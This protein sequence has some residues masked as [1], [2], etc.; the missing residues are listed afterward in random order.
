[1]LDEN[2]IQEN[3]LKLREMVNTEFSGERADNLNRLYDYFEE[4]MILAP[5]SGKEHFHNAFPGGYVDH[6]LRVIDLS[7]KEMELW[8]SAGAIINFTRE[9]LVFS[10]MHHDL[11]KV[12]D[13][14]N[15][16]Y[17]PN[18]SQWHTE[19]QG[20]I[21]AFNPE[22]EHTPGHLQTQYLLQ[23]FNVYCSKRE[24]I[25]I[26]C[27]DGMYSTDAESILKQYEASRQLRSNLPLILH[28]AD[29][30]A[31]RVEYDT[32]YAS[33]STIIEQKEEVKKPVTFKKQNL[34]KL[35]SIAE[36]ATTEA[37]R[38]LFDDLF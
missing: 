25:A 16:Y 21:Y 30:L 23:Y 31:S 17:I 18:D 38:K 6:V 14:D 13:L 1:M 10:A 27:A 7:L 22:L 35:S 4:R 32:W 5:A 36:N 19:K 29:M 3:W 15:D 11:Y 33:K 9:E 28:H 12:G 2:K 20:L 26:Q 24:M 37:Q 8:Q 34:S